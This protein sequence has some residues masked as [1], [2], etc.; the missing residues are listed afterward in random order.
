MPCNSGFANGESPPKARQP[1]EPQA[2]GSIVTASSRRD[3]LES[4]LILAYQLL[5]PRFLALPES[6]HLMRL[7]TAEFQISTSFGGFGEG[8]LHRALSTAG[9]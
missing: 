9:W 7:M 8:A 5:G 6:W 1:S 2:H 4:C 3:N